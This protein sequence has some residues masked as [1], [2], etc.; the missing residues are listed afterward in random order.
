MPDNLKV[1]NLSKRYGSGSYVIEKLS[2]TFKPGTATGLVG[3]NGS[4]KTTFL[5]LISTTAFPTSGS[6][7]YGEI[8]IHKQPGRY[9]QH[10]GLVSDSTGLP[11]Y[12]SAV[13]LLSWILR[14][15]D[16]WDSKSED[17]IRSLLDAVS[18]D[19]RREN[20]IGTYSSGMVQK[21][22]I[23]ASLIANPDIILL[24]EPFRALD[25]DSTARTLELLHSFRDNGGTILISS[26]IQASLDQLCEDYLTFPVS[27][28]VQQESDG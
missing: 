19:E 10:V 16:K 9:L 1:E 8:N 20:L 3:P 27:E 5:R 25:E 26:H 15:R 17:R 18:L 24:D 6:V 2:A 4:G 12:L 28:T 14:S 7:H 13:E 22:L 11:E 21:T 23:A